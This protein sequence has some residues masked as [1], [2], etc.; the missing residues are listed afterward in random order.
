MRTEYRIIC[1]MSYSGYFGADN[2]VLLLAQKV[3]V[4]KAKLAIKCAG[5]S[6]GAT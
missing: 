3:K 6:L 2:L 5:R 1:E 4:K